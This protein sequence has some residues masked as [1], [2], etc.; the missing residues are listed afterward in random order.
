ME[1]IVNNIHK[2][3]TTLEFRLLGMVYFA[4]L[5]QSILQHTTP[6]SL[7]N[8]GYKCV[9]AVSFLCNWRLMQRVINN[10]AELISFVYGTKLFAV[11]RDGL[12]VL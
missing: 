3:T 10:S 1:M 9:Y 5:N 6:K 4:F 11:Y 2:I 7:V 8:N 12:S